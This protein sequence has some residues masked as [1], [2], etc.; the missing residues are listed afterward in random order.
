MPNRLRIDGIRELEAA[1]RALPIELRDEAAGVVQAHASAAEG[2]IRAAYPIGP[3]RYFKK[4]D[5]R[6]GGGELRKGLQSA[7]ETS[8]FG[9][10]IRLK[11]TAKHAWIFEN[12]TELRHTDLGRNRGRMPAGKVFIPIVIRER[13]AM[14]D[15][16]VAIVERA[17]LRVHGG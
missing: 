14:V 7:S 8:R 12:G 1:L 9:T 6:Y 10:R 17:G 5:Y 4:L 13:R 2:A 3:A 16:L 15:D 11:N